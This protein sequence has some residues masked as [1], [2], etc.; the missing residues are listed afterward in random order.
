MHTPEIGTRFSTRAAREER[1]R[2]VW[3]FCRARLSIVL[4]EHQAVMV[5]PRPY[6]PKSCFVRGLGGNRDFV[7]RRGMVGW[8][9]VEGLVS[10][11]GKLRRR[12]LNR[13]ACVRSSRGGSDGGGGKRHYVVHCRKVTHQ[14]ACLAHAS[15]AP[16]AEAATLWFVSVPCCIS[17]L[18]FRSRSCTLALPT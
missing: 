10:P 13:L 2:T 11:R 18:V 1:F 7:P 6:R 4:Y 17:S 3:S 5:K 12:V 9:S 15:M 8:T 14:P 16:D